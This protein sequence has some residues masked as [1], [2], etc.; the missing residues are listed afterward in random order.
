[1][2]RH[3]AWQYLIFFS[4]I[5]L[6][7]VAICEL[8]Q[9]TEAQHAIVSCVEKQKTKCT[10]RHCAAS[11]IITAIHWRKNPTE[12]LITQRAVLPRCAL[13]RQSG[14]IADSG[15]IELIFRL[16]FRGAFYDV[17]I[18]C[19]LKQVWFQIE[20]E[21]RKNKKYLINSEKYLE[22]ARAAKPPRAGEAVLGNKY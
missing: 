8:T 5:N 21:G 16:D 4:Q 22:P 11:S 15:F 3:S 7:G 17:I 14:W 6:H 1:M 20:G 19:K 10:C 2:T 18:G 9:L 12:C 13:N